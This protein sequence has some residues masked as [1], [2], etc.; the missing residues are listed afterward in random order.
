MGLGSKDDQKRTVFREYAG[1][2][3]WKATIKSVADAK[4]LIATVQE[5]LA[6]DPN[7]KFIMDAYMGLKLRLLEAY[8]ANGKDIPLKQFKQ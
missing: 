1:K 2:H 8:I 5:N 4:A 3:D 6:Q 7:G